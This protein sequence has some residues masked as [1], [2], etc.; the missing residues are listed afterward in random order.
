[1]VIIFLFQHTGIHMYTGI[2]CTC[3]DT[4]AYM[5]TDTLAY[6][7]TDTLAYTYTDIHV[8]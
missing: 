8:H 6:T 4:L 2:T 7:Y 1:M 3:T 5:Y